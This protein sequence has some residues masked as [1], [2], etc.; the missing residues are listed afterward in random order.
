MPLPATERLLL[1]PGPSLIAPRVMRALGAPVLGHLDPEF[2]PMLDDV[3]ASL[4]RVF[5]TDDH[6]LTLAPS[7]PGAPAREAA[8]PTAVADGMRAVVVVTGYFADRMVQ[9]MQRYGASVRRIDVEWGRACAPQR[10][11]DELRREG[12][13]IVGL[14]H[15]ETSTG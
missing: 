4:R 14:V 15:A 13:D 2:V 9:M 7:R 8:V 3:R 12:A 6:A 10:L 11:R 1:G 5:R